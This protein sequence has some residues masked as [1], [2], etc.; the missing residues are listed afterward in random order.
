MEF[1]RGSGGQRWRKHYNILREEIAQEEK[2]RRIILMKKQRK[3]G[4]IWRGARNGYAR[5][6]EE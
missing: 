3:R 2:K 4:M 6:V 1:R 5:T